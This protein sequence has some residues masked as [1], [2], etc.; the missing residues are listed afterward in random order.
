MKVLSVMGSPHTEGNTATVLGWVED[1]LKADGHQVSRVNVVEHNINGCQACYACKQVSDAP[2]CVIKDDT[3]QVLQQFI[4]NDL[5]LLA[6]PLYGWGYPAQLKALLDRCFSLKKPLGDTNIS[7]VSGKKMALLM[8]AAGP[9]ENNLALIEPVLAGMAWF[10][11]TEIAGKLLLPGCT[12]P[13]ELGDEVKAQ[14]VKF[15]GQLGSS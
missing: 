9:Y 12:K 7:L 13:A 8:T 3:E 10:M 15:A 11:E 1:S 5:L 14:A 2:G 6:S 4:D